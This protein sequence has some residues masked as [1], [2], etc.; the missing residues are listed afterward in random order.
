MFKF[1]SILILLFA[2]SP[3][4]AQVDT[5]SV[6]FNWKDENITPS[7]KYNNPYNEVWGFVNNNREFAVIGSTDGTRIFDITDS[8]NEKRVAFIPGAFQGNEV[9]HRDY[10]DNKGYLYAVC[11]ESREES[12]LQIIDISNL[13]ASFEVVY[14]SNE[15]FGKTHN[16]FIDNDKLYA[17]KGI[18]TENGSISVFPMRIYSLE[19]PTDPELLYEYD[20]YNV[21]DLFVRD[22]IAFLN[23]GGFGLFVLDFS[24]PINPK[25]ITS[26]IEYPFKGYNHSGCLNAEGTHYFFTDENFTLPIKAVDIQDL[27]NMNVVATFS[28]ETDSIAIAHNVLFRDDYLFASYYYD[29][30]QIFDVSDPNNPTKVCV[31][32]TSKLEHRYFYEGAWGIYPYLPSGKILVSD[33]QEGLFVLETNLD[34]DRSSSINEI[35]VLNTGKAYPSLFDQELNFENLR[36]KT[37]DNLQLNI[38]N[39]NGKLISRQNCIYTNPLNIKTDDLGLNVGV[40]IFKLFNEQQSHSFKVVKVNQ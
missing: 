14:D 29:G 5:A 3:L 27:E 34:L 11:G 21:H 25:N 32:P 20:G 13:P 28:P 36:F 15:L 17:C 33:M 7:S 9:V 31:Y 19:N 10:H 4:F 16:I 12:T 2:S 26:L 24:D 22:D 23:N 38:F 40:Y 18:A 35:Q 1:L 37:G 6:I 30:L 39:A 8:G